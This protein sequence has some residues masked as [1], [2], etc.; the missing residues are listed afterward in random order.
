MAQATPEES[1]WLHIHLGIYGSWRF[2]GDENFVAPIQGDSKICGPEVEVSLLNEK[3]SQAPE[4]TRAK[5]RTIREIPAH[6]QVDDS[7]WAPHEHFADRWFVMPGGFQPFEPIGTVRLRLLT[8]HGVADLVGPNRCELMSWEEVQA[9]QARLG[10]DPL[11]A[12]PDFNSFVKRLATR[13]KGIG[14]ALMDQSVIAG[15][16]NIYRAEVLYAARLHPFRPAREVTG[17]KLKKIWDWLQ[18]YMPLGVESGRVTT[19]ERDDYASFVQRETSK[20]KEI[21]PIDERYYVYQ[22]DHRP[23]IRCG[24]TIRLEIVAGRKLY[25][26]P[27]CQR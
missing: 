27:R 11:G 4:K 18:V 19:I 25:W 12:N 26:C 23:C 14:E 6:F 22:R 3:N 2:T 5:T 15:V 13:Q 9:T 21:K 8:E 10:P 7:V 24:A 16:G 20:G 17:A 1:L